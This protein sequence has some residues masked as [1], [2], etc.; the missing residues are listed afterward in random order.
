MVY[1]PIDEECCQTEGSECK[2]DEVIRQHLQLP[3]DV[4]LLAIRDHVVEGDVPEHVQ[5][6]AQ[7]TKDQEHN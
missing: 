2:V 4:L 3:L 1:P 5:Q 6:T 7:Q